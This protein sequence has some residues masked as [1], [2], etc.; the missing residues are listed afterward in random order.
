MDGSM[1]AVSSRPLIL[2]LIALLVAGSAHAKSWPTPAMGPSAS[3]DPEVLF[4]FDDGPHVTHTPEVLAILAQ[5][6]V[7]AVFFLVGRNLKK[8]NPKARDLVGKITAAGHVIGNHTLTHMAMCNKGMTDEKGVIELDQADVLIR[9]V[10][11]QERIVW[12]RTPFGQRCERIEKLL[13]E[14]HLDHMHWDVDP[15]EWRTKD[16]DKTRNMIIGELKSL[17]GRAVVLLHDI[18]PATV[19]ALPGVFSWIEEENVRR[20]KSGDRPIRILEPADIA[21]ERISPGLKE[22]GAGTAA[23]LETAAPDVVRRLLGPLVAD[24]KAARL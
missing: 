5:H 10:S 17:R 4:T 13:A 23:F 19:A 8:G 14:R 12:F 11:G 16:G 2:P 24:A 9:E 15:Q 20:K 18:Q 6:K 1:F 21:I 3:G 7:K 22:A